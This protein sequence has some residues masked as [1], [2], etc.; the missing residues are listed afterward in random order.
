MLTE[1]P[2]VERIKRKNIIDTAPGFTAMTRIFSVRS[3]A[4]IVLS[5]P[6]ASSVAGF[7]APAEAYP[8]LPDA[9][10]TG[11]NSPR[12]NVGVQGRVWLSGPLLIK[13]LFEKFFGEGYIRLHPY[14]P[15]GWG[16]VGYTVNLTS[17]SFISGA[18]GVVK[19]DPFSVSC[20]VLLVC[21]GKG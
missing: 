5:L 12:H 4:R 11:S 2:D 9:Y 6:V 14:T 20:W 7:S 19:W 18:S 21:V 13:I 8:L 17:V 10:D 16:A 3:K 1:R 15:R